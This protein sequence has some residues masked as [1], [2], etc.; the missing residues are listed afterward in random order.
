VYPTATFRNKVEQHLKHWLK[1]PFEIT[2]CIASERPATIER[3]PFVGLHPLYPAVGI[4]NG[5]GTKGC[6]L[7]P[8]FARQLTEHLL[9]EKP[10]DKEVDVQRFKKVI[11]IETL[12]R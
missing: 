9:Q 8:F 5:M 1:L 11:S 4:L 7:A 10:L 6:S 3:R 2:G 12:P